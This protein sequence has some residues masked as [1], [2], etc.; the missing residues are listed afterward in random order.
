MPYSQPYPLKTSV[1][2]HKLMKIS[3][4]HRLKSVKFSHFRSVLLKEDI[5]KLLLKVTTIENK[6]NFESEIS[7]ILDK[8]KGT[9]VN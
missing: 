9:V 6:Q 1:S 7:F 5:R 2:I 4:F 8:A 3:F